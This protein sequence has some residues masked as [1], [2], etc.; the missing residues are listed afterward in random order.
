MILLFFD[1]IHSEALGE[2]HFLFLFLMLLLF[3]QI[4]LIALL[5]LLFLL[6]K[7]IANHLFTLAASLVQSLVGF[8]GILGRDINQYFCETSL[9]LFII[10]V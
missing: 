7:Q 10:I 1:I 2:I 4:A 3:L 9:F 5:Y 8:S 6:E